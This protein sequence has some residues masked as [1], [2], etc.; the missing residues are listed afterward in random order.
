[1]FD[2][3]D[4]EE[5]AEQAL[6]EDSLGASIRATLSPFLP[7][8][9]AVHPEGAARLKDPETK[10]DEWLAIFALPGRFGWRGTRYPEKEAKIIFKALYEF[11]ERVG[12][13]FHS[14]AAE[15]A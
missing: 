13:V 3:L 11:E 14:R 10:A 7:Q 4:E 2:D 12:D 1:M 9:E 5:R 6:I 8:L 15:K